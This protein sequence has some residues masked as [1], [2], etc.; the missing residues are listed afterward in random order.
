MRRQTAGLLLLL[1]GSAVDSS[2]G[3]LT[4]ATGADAFTT[5]SA[6][7]LI[8][9][10][11][12]FVVLALRGDPF[13]RIRRIGA[14]GLFFAASNSFGMVLNVLSL[15]FTAVANFFMIFATAPFLAALLAWLALRERP[16]GATLLAAVAGVAGIAVMVAGGLAG[17]N[18]GDGLALVVVLLYSANV[19]ILR[20]AP[21]MDVLALVTLTTLFSGLAAAPFARFGGL[22]PVDWAALAALGMG[23]LAV[24]NLLIFS[25]VARVTPAQAGLLGIMGAVFAPLWMLAGRGEIPPPATLAGGAIILV[26]GLLHFLWTVT[27]KSA[28]QAPAEPA[29]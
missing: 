25:A 21:K 29:F 24:G 10:A 28:A 7:G 8:A 22:G 16:D 17:V 15:K 6:R 19:L 23:Q 13:G 11:V 4:R 1:A 14:W 12:L 20:R 3:L 18:L 2:S 5:A 9:F 27:R 26:A